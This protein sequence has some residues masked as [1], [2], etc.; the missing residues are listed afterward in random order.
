MTSVDDPLLEH[1]SRS[2]VVSNDGVAR[3]PATRS[4]PRSKGSASRLG[5]KWSRL[6]HVYASM[7]SF[8]VVLLFAFTGLMLNHP[9]WTLGD[10]PN[11]TETSGEVPVELYADDGSLDFLT[12]SEFARSELGARGEVTSFGEVAG[13]ASIIYAG[14]GFAADLIVDVDTGTYDY[15]SEQQGWVAVMSDFH[16]GK[17]TGGAWSLAIDAAA[18]FLLVVSLSGIVLQF[19]LKKR[20]RSAYVAAGVGGALVVAVVVSVLF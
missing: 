1:A 12:L 15:T 16:T 17:D 11:V 13:E 6:V 20:R 8:V 9:T 19:F 2:D 18:V 5:Q 14:P 7:I 3:R 4:V 10:D